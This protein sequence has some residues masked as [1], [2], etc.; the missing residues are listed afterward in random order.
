[1]EELKLKINPEILALLAESG[2]NIS[3]NEKVNLSLSIFLFTD[4]VVTLARAA[5]L[6]GISM[7]DFIKVLIRHNI[8]WCEYSKE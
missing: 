2:S 5:E 3:I 1:M 8:P 6:S 4:R 7:S